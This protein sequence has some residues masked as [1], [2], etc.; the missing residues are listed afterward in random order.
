ML[1][2]STKRVA[3]ADGLILLTQQKACSQSLLL[4]R[5]Y[6]ETGEQEAPVRFGPACVG[7]LWN[8]R[9]ALL[10]LFSLGPG[11]GVCHSANEP[12]PSRHRPA[13]LPQRCGNDMYE[14]GQDGLSWSRHAWELLPHAPNMVTINPELV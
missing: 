8:I 10:D 6:T 11:G 2:D 7:L 5:P 13:Q 12:T 1:V 3:E 14:L 4:S 9:A